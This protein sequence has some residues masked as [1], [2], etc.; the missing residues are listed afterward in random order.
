MTSTPLKNSE[1]LTHE[2]KDV[3]P[4]TPVKLVNISVITGY[5]FPEENLEKSG[6]SSGISFFLNCPFGNFTLI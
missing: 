6:N 4:S 3:T 2:K 5:I 1:E